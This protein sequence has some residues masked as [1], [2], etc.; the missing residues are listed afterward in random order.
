MILFLIPCAVCAI[1]L[2]VILPQ[3]LREAAEQKA[4][5]P[6]AD[7]IQS[8]V[9]IDPPKEIAPEDQPDFKSFADAW[10]RDRLAT[11]KA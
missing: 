5:N 9:G 6:T 7:E 2:A 3:T 8:L 10:V 11:R 4:A 1:L